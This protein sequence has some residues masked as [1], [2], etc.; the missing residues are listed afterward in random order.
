MQEDSG[1]AMK[2]QLSEKNCF[3]MEEGALPGV[4]K[5]ARRVCEDFALVFAG[6]PEC[7]ASLSGL[8]D[9]PVLFGT[10]GHSE[11]LKKYE[12]KGMFKRQTIEGR[13][14][15]YSISV[16]E[17]PVR[18]DR[19]ALLIAG[20]DKRGTIYGLFHLSEL[21]GVSP[22][23]YWCKVQPVKQKEVILT[24]EQMGVSKE[25]S[26]K[27]RGF[28]INDEWPAFGN[29]CNRRFGGFTAAMYEQVF[30]LLLRLKG[31]YLWPAMWSSR[32]SV[33]GPGLASAVLADEM[34][35]I[36]G[37]SH[38]EPCLRH[39][40]E[41]RYLRGKDSVYGDAWNFRTNEEGITRFWKDGLIRNGKFENVIT[42]GMRGEADSA[43][44]GEQATLADNINLLRDVLRTQNRLIKEHV[45]E[46]LDKVPRMLALYKEVE[47]F[48]YG[49]AETEGLKDSEELE[50][51]TLMLC[52]DNFGNLRTLPTEEMRAHR[53]GYG[54]YYHF[55][56]HGLPVSFEWVNSSYLP[57]V[58]E[59]MTQ[60]Y[61]FGIRELWIV[62]VGDIFTN[63]FPLSFFLDLAYDY[64]KWGISN[65]NSPDEYTR[66]FVEKQFGAWLDDKQK[67]DVVHILKGNTRLGHNRRPEAMRAGVYAPLA[68]EETKRVLTEV[69]E[70]MQLTDTIYENCEETAK[71]S[72]FWLL[73]Y[74]VMANLNVQKLQ[75]LT[76]LNH[77]YAQQQRN[78]ANEIAD[79]VEN[80][81]QYDEMLIRKLHTLDHEH[82]YGMGM[83]EHI[84][85]QRWNEEECQYP[86]LYRFKPA[87]KLRMVVSVPGTQQHTQG[88]DWTKQTLYLDDFLSPD[89]RE[90]YL[91]LSAVGRM[92]PEY[93]IICTD[94]RLT[95]REEKTSNEGVV[96]LVLTRKQETGKELSEEAVF[97][98]E[99]EFCHTKVV[100]LFPSAFLAEQR[101]KEPAGTF[102]W[103]GG[104]SED[105]NYCGREYIS[106]EAAHYFE[107]SDTED[108]AFVEIP[109]YGK[110][111]SGMK[112]FPV[113]A[114]FDPLQNAPELSYRFVL[115]KEDTCIVRFLLTPSNPTDMN[116]RLLF[117]V[118]V[119]E[120]EI[121]TVNAIKESFAVADRN[122]E[123]E[124]GVLDNIRVCEHIIQGKEGANLLH[125]YAMEPGFV[126][127]KIVIFPQGKEP[128]KCYLE[129]PETFRQG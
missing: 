9:F 85:F 63:E 103:C 53:G 6:Q 19:Q 111:L 24:E 20:S 27:Y 28:F 80:C 110:T 2:F 49:D 50:G 88:G 55:D 112:A 119:N 104:S 108:G 31:N 64:E 86:I 82:F 124:R 23:A 73:Y 62:N 61:E 127:E 107:K 22:L 102:L 70:L 12:E 84:G 14:E 78:Q 57:K 79:M 32:F 30:E 52:D 29:W 114:F 89:R 93:R 115:P 65:L 66:S 56:Y 106:M 4:L 116:K 113:T 109:E 60:A 121:E 87:N 10:L 94:E 47:P 105:G 125:V 99:S 91:E 83:S 117:G 13:R 100:V 123:W 51:V 76:G 44:M 58:W 96:H 92:L 122:E 120:G 90:V 36:M 59:Q 77:A 38:H 39:G 129:V 40:E 74:P 11:L 35:V 37:M 8:T 42:V 34:G 5:I 33:D 43:I 15:V 45:N 54:M 3:Y 18:K 67:Q 98:I 69:Q 41:Y 48:F 46:D 118:S 17:H 101:K 26:V 126:L 21:I 16:V 72:M 25:P 97:H 1:V 81:L 128:M 68:Y 95:I 75:L 71:C 7:C